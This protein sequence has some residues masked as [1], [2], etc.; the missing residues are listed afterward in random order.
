MPTPV[1]YRTKEPTTRNWPELKIT[2]E[3]VDRQFGQAEQNIG[4]VLGARSGG[5]VDVDLD[6]DEAVRLAPYFLPTTTAVFG[7]ASKPRS[8]FLYRVADA[9]S[10]AGKKLTGAD[11]ACIV[12]L[13]TGGG[14]KGA[15]TVFPGSTHAS[16]E[17]IEWAEEGETA[18]STF[19]TLNGSIKKI[20][21]ATIMIRSFPPHGGRHEA[22][23][24]LGGFFARAGWGVEDITAFV[25][26]VAREGGSS[27]PDGRAR[28]AA[29]AATGFAE[30]ENVYGY[31]KVKEIFGEAATRAVAKIVDYR[32][33]TSEGVSMDDFVAYLPQH[34][35]IFIPTREPWPAASVNSRIAPVR[36]GTDDDGE[37]NYVKANAWL[38]ANKAVEQMTWAPGHPMLIR[39]QI[40]AEGGWLERPG[41]SCFNLY[42]PPTIIH[43]NPSEAGPWLEHVRRVYPTDA[44]HIIKWLAH[45]VQHPSVKINHA[46][47]LGGEQGIGKDTILEPVKRAVGPW[48]FCEVSPQNMLGRFNGYLK[49][50]ILRISE[51]RDLGDVNR[52]SFY[53][54][55]KVVTASPPDVLRVDEKNL[56]EHSIL[57]CCGVVITSNFKT[58]GIYLPAE[59]RRNYVAWSDLKK[60]NFNKEYWTDL[61]QWYSEGGHANVAAYLAT[62]DI[63]AFDPKAPPP[64]TEAFYAI[65][66]SNVA[67]EE[68]E[69]AD[70][71]DSLGNPR[72]VTLADITARALRQINVG[73]GDVWTWIT[74]RRNRRAIPHKLERCGYVPVRNTDRLDG[75]WIIGGKRQAVYAQRTLSLHDQFAAA[76]ELRARPA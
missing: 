1:K 73:D 69:L 43:G 68:G 37:P 63:S 76:S 47:F 3:N 15:Q 56:R 72:A 53:E 6:C 33:D 14:S 50:V 7:R 27:D 10:G 30:G 52:F 74:D 42:R 38:D 16:G 40:A 26:V 34:T 67:P 75:L 19:E 65:V 29:A 21:A 32:G 11:G 59:D 20:A 70:I 62:L 2:L 46:V 24:A 66:N 49:S 41:L 35:Y 61:Y 18:Q 51:A 22:A 28:D 9:P 71:L 17:M 8:H 45:R 64:K 39:D 13:R 48:N 12:E 54:H 57:N 44:E 58:D 60:E 25:E 4:V 5:L 23:L 31:P 36:V 55:M